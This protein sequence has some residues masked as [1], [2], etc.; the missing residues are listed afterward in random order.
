MCTTHRPCA[1][2][3]SPE[4][5]RSI[6]TLNT[7][8]RVRFETRLLSA[9]QA[10]A[11]GWIRCGSSLSPLIDIVQPSPAAGPVAGTCCRPSLNHHY[12]GSHFCPSKV[13][14]ARRP[15]LTPSPCSR[16]GPDALVGIFVVAKEEPSSKRGHVDA[17]A[18]AL[19]ACGRRRSLEPL[20]RPL[21]E[22]PRASRERVRRGRLEPV[23]RVLYRPRTCL[24]P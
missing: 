14:T 21:H 12:P 13:T 16:T 15:R 19:A 11:T 17:C 23:K 3:C 18:R 10:C 24:G 6:A 2:V 20:R 7:R 9:V 5:C 22:R 4:L 8:C 1:T